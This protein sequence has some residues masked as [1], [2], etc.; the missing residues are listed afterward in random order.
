MCK[1]SI[2]TTAIEVVVP[3]VRTQGAKDSTS[4]STSQGGMKQQTCSSKHPHNNQLRINT[5]HWN[6][7][8]EAITATLD[9]AENEDDDLEEERKAATEIHKAVKGRG[10]E[11]QH[12]SHVL[13]EIDANNQQ[14]VS[15]PVVTVPV[16][17]RT[18]EGEQ[19]LFERR[20]GHLSMLQCSAAQHV[21]TSAFS[22]RH[23][24]DVYLGIYLI[25][26][27][28]PILTH[29]VPLTHICVK[30]LNARKTQ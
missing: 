16:D 2:C 14:V 26:M 19:V 4:I 13:E 17:E 21:Q 7:H 8:N 25:K 15:E 6:V 11:R 12:L 30:L 27:A 28:A 23:V 10:G 18:S 24:S 9:G 22:R 1:W 29:Y 3:K 20:E 5:C